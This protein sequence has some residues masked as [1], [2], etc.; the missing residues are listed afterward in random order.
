M[1]QPLAQPGSGFGIDASKI[2][3]F[4]PEAS[5][6]L[7]VTMRA[8]PHVLKSAGVRSGRYTSATGKW[9]SGIEDASAPSLRGHATGKP[10]IV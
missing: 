5:F 10:L 7:A 4:R 1:R 2:G 9:L 3:R 6:G 8:S